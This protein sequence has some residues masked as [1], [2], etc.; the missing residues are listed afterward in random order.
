[1][2]C[3]EKQLQEEI[4]SHKGAS[5]GICNYYTLVTNYRLIQLNSCEHFLTSVH[6]KDPIDFT[7]DVVTYL[8]VVGTVVGVAFDG[9]VSDKCFIIMMM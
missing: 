9:S 4:S 2:T 6:S 3:K 1:M 5:T 7:R 8:I